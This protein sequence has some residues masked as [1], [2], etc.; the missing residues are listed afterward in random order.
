M[1]PRFV[2]KDQMTTKWYCSE[3]R[4]AHLLLALLLEFYTLPHACPWSPQFRLPSFRIG[5]NFLNLNQTLLQ[6]LHDVILIWGTTEKNRAHRVP[7]V[8]EYSVIGTLV[9]NSLPNAELDTQQFRDKRTKLLRTVDH[10]AG[11]TQWLQNKPGSD[12]RQ[13]VG[14]QVMRSKLLCNRK[15]KTLDFLK[16]W[17]RCAMF[18]V[19]SE[20]SFFL[21]FWVE[22][23]NEM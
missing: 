1:L 7:C 10:A 16:M 5:M 12:S 17:P 20:L 3:K 8:I 9:L 13:E 4:A 23:S 11:T 21:S 14:Q 19:S 18:S 6:G 15:K 22:T 2:L